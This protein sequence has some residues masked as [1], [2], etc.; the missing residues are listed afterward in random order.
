M[1]DRC[2]I[3]EPVT[4]MCV[5]IIKYRYIFRYGKCYFPRPFHRL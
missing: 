5:R 1:A 4:H 3:L 2:N